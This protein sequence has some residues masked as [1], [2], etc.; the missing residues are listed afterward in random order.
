MSSVY[1][2]IRDS[3]EAR[4][5]FSCDYQGHRREVCAHTLGRK[6][7]EEKVL[8]FQ[9][10]GGSSSGLPEGGQWR[11]MFIAQ[12]SAVELIEGP[13]HS[14]DEHTQPQTCVD[15]VDMEVFV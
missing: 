15:D 3:M 2:M 4:K 10:A 14:S 7:G 9:Y 12:I 6:N 11:C 13:W 1:Q 8:T 5:P